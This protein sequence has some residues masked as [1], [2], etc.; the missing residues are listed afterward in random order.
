LYFYGAGQNAYVKGNAMWPYISENKTVFI[1]RDAL[2]RKGYQA[3]IDELESV[4]AAYGDVVIKDYTEPAV[5]KKSKKLPNKGQEREFL[6]S[7]VHD[8]QAAGIT[9]ME[10]DLVKKECTPTGVIVTTFLEAPEDKTNKLNS[11]KDNVE[12]KQADTSKLV[13]SEQDQRQIVILGDDPKYDEFKLQY[14][15]IEMVHD[16][17][18]VLNP[19]NGSLYLKK[20]IGILERLIILKFPGVVNTMETLLR[21]TFNTES[22]IEDEKSVQ[23]LAAAILKKIQVNT[24]FTI[25]E[26]CLTTVVA[27]RKSLEQQIISHSIR[28]T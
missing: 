27:F 18:K 6:A 14:D 17:R 1:T 11:S 15:L 10:T 19:T 8:D 2:K 21:I 25:S 7:N 22:T 9:L 28:F 23:T 4:F 5:V 26:K 12:G 3:A 13:S 20:A 24:A 16:I